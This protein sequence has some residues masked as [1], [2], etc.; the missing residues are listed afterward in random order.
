[1][2]AMDEAPESL[3]WTAL[4]SG[5]A[6]FRTHRRQQVDDR[7]EL[8]PSGHA[9]MLIATSAITGVVVLLGGVIVW[10]THDDA[11]ALVVGISMFVVAQTLALLLLRLLDHRH[12]F[13][14]VS[15]RYSWTKRPAGSLALAELRGLQVTRKR[16][17]GP[18]SDYDSDELNL[19]FANGRRVNVLDHGD[20]ESLRADANA[21][22]EWLGKPLWIR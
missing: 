12:V 7:F 15:G 10:R 8:V 5:G 22:A 17:I 20:A 11:G 13:D 19:V 16:V 1:M 14:R 2:I 9:R 18:E 21:L 4:R 6:V 3:D